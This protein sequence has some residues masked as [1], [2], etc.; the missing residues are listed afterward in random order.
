MKSIRLYLYVL[1]AFLVSCSDSFFD[2]RPTDAL[3]L[4]GFF[5]S[6]E[7]FKDVINSAYSNLRSVYENFYAFGDIASDDVF[8]DKFSNNFDRI[9]INESNVTSSNGIIS[10]FWNNS[11]VVI[12]RCNLVLDNIQDF[13]MDENQKKQLQGEALFIRALCYFNMV[14]IFGDVPLVLKDL[15][16]PSEVFEYSRAPVEEVYAQIMQDL[17]MIVAGRYLPVSY[18]QN[19]DMGRANHYAAQT[20]LAHIYLTRQDYTNAGTLLADVTGNTGIHYLLPLYEDIFDATNPNNPEVIFAIQYASGFTPSMGNPFCSAALPNEA[21]GSG[22][23]N[24]GNGHFL[25]TEDLMS[26]FEPDDV[27]QQMIVSMTGVRREHILPLKYRDKTNTV[28]IDAGNDWIV[29]RYA[30]VLLMYAETLIEK[31]DLQGAVQLIR[32]VRERAG[33][34]TMPPVSSA[35]EIKLA[36]ENE[37]RLELFC[38]GHR[39]FDLLRTGRLQTIMNAHFKSGADDSQIGNGTCSIVD[40]ELIF[41]I[42]KFQV[43]LNP[44]KLKQNPGY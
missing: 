15:T 35:Q 30:D 34:T 31:N 42:P 14:R 5:I 24:F 37:R 27:R 28:R 21:I 19:A 7:N 29:Y 18:A 11:Y 43:D 1:C 10:S 25:I 12:N 36:I 33:L 20:L 3:S 32:E 38:E 40:Y 17:N 44:D 2:K 6:S 41:P 23:Y 13:S 9:T 16:T 4:G 8:I 39:W 22:L 26:H